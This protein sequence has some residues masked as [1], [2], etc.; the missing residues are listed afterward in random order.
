MT[1][2]TYPPYPPTPQ[3]IPY[4]YPTYGYPPAWGYAPPPPQPPATAEPPKSGRWFVPVFGVLLTVLT[5]GAL[6]LAFFA[7]STITP[8]SP[9]S[10]WAQ[11]YS[12]T[13]SESSGAWDV[14]KGC[15]FTTSGL[16]TASGATCAFLPSQKQ[17]LTSQGFYFSV[18]LAPAGDVAQE[19]Q[20]A[21]G[22]G[23]S[24]WMCVDQF[25]TYILSTGA[26]DTST[27]TSAQTDTG[28]VASLH[29]DALVANTLSVLYDAQKE[30]VTYAVN[31][32]PFATV[33]VVTQGQGTTI[34][35]GTGA[36]G[37]AIFTSATLY[38]ANGGQ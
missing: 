10:N 6:A 3:N 2:P 9:P 4:G 30:T 32:Q 21:I 19:E 25:G 28:E 16:Y 33:Q 12:G 1:T 26:C 34:S 8:L 23:D 22:L 35:L 11:V 13:P 36:N 18:T 14:T 17:D 5:L 24:L 29:T 27:A 31:G 7:P 38:S 15:E 20:G 37:G